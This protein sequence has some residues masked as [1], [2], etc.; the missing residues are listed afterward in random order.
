[1][2]FFPDEHDNLLRPKEPETSAGSVGSNAYR[3]EPGSHCTSNTT[4]QCNQG[5]PGCSGSSGFCPNFVVSAAEPCAGPGVCMYV[6]VLRVGQDERCLLQH[7]V[8]CPGCRLVLALSSLRR[9]GVCPDPALCRRRQ[10]HLVQCFS[11]CPRAICFASLNTAVIFLGHAA[12]H[13]CQAWPTSI[14]C[15]PKPAASAQPPPTPTLALLMLLM[16]TSATSQLPTCVTAAT[17]LWAS[18]RVPTHPRACA[19]A[20]PTSSKPPH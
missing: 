5:T 13:S 18:N 6:C 10:N 3:T 1:M 9:Q 7:A 20:L 11:L 16:L 4:S 15:T 17:R 19:S 8:S 12:L 2:A 14:S